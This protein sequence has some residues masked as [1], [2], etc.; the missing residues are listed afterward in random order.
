MKIST[1]TAQTKRG[2]RWPVCAEASNRQGEH[3]AR[4][5]FR[6]H[7]PCGPVSVVPQWLCTRRQQPLVTNPLQ[8]HA[9][10][11]GLPIFFFPTL[12]FLPVCSNNS[13]LSFVSF[14][15]LLKASAPLCPPFFS[16]SLFAQQRVNLDP[17]TPLYLYRR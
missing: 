6:P 1:V 2:N 7:F 12:R 5:C 10:Q 8:F 13:P 4:P 9:A 17:R 15:L 16:L 14:F 11:R 3:V